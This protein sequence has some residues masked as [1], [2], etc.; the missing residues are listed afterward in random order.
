MQV[1]SA[2]LVHKE[3]QAGSEC[4]YRFD[5]EVQPDICDDGLDLILVA[6]GA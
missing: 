2:S 6:N 5:A 1:E 3:T 4:I